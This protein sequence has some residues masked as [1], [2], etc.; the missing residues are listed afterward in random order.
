MKKVLIIFMLF[1]ASVTQADIKA[2]SN[3]LVYKGST[4]VS[5][6]IINYEKYQYAI[7]EW[8]RRD[9]SVETYRKDGKVSRF[10]YQAP[11]NV[12]KEVLHKFYRDFFIKNK[13]EVVFES[14]SFRSQAFEQLYKDG[15]PKRLKNSQH[16]NVMYNS[17]FMIYFVVKN[18]N[19]L[20]VMSFSQ[21][22]KDN[23]AYYCIDIVENSIITTETLDLNVEDIAGAINKNSKMVLENI[24]FEES[25]FVL[26]EMSYRN[27]KVVSD[28]MIDYPNK[29]FYLVVH[30][31]DVG[32]YNDNKLLSEM[33][34][35][36][37]V[38][39]LTEKYGINESRLMAI[40]VGP[41]SPVYT[42]DNVGGRAANNRVELVVKFQ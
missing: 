14:Y 7:S 28:Y 19:Q 30:T 5:H 22:N 17:G 33:R 4:D 35:K 20:V 38:K 15:I 39:V 3:V 41:V 36:E 6:D 10:L 12:T 25:D 8:D 26:E 2:H 32:D 23:P 9:R 1:I 24:I 37:I 16:Y 27:I 21:K 40:G 13:Y 18:D 11:I 29:S 42:N 31:D 34:S